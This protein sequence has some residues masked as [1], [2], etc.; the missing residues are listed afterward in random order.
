MPSINLL[1]WRAEL[2]KRRQKEFLVGL[3][4]ALGLAVVVALLGHF[5]VSTMIDAQQARNDLLKAE[6][7]GL[8]KQ[9][10][11]IIALEAQKARMVARMEVIEKLQKS[12]PE[13]VKLFDDM[14]KALPE[15]VYLSSVKQSARRLEFNGV[16]QS[17]TRVSAFMRNIDSSE[18]LA[19]PDLKVI[20]TGT[21]GSGSRF[22]LF[23]QLKGP[24]AEAEVE[25]PAATRRVKEASR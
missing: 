12:R 24:G 8:D 14:V 18:V 2:R 17:S 6:I 21:P 15:G 3:A 20:E 4:G 16:A 7:A 1:P 23:A 25:S 5:T 13:V 22:T 11:E 19:K 10:E 9:I